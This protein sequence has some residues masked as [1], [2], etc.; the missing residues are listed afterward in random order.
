M[1][2]HCYNSLAHFYDNISNTIRSRW[3]NWTETLDL[4]GWVGQPVADVRGKFKYTYPLG[5]EKLAHFREIE[6]IKDV[7]VKYWNQFDGFDI[8]IDRMMA[9]QD[10]LLNTHKRRLLPKTVDV[11]VNIGEHCEVNS[12]A[13]L[14]KTYAAIKIVDKL[15][16]LG[17]RCAVYACNSYTTIVKKGKPRESGYIEVR[18]KDYA[19][20]LNIGLMCTAISPWMFLHWFILH[21]TGRHHN[22]EN[23]V[24]QTSALPGDLRGIII[25]SG[26]CLNLESANTTIQSIKL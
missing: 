3:F 19:D 5:V 7:K 23:G 12:D 6:A 20:P 21:I 4:P 25:D 16:T 17:V 15:E 1:K 2:K 10:Y 24:A 13:M 9:S 8:D 26:Q 18:I 11:Y 14:C 22:I